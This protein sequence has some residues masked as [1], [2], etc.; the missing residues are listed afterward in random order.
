MQDFYTEINP[1]TNKSFG[2]NDQKRNSDEFQQRVVVVFFILRHKAKDLLFI[3]LKP[4]PR[5]P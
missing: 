1:L 4:P 3:R 2:K 5:I